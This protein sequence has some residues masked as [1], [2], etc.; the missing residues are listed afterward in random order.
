MKEN[1]SDKM[2]KKVS[3]AIK[4]GDQMMATEEK[5][6]LETAQRESA[7]RRQESGTEYKPKLFRKDENGLWVYKYANKAPFNPN[8]VRAVVE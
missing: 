5:I 2:W 8:E 4:K 7:K 3:E 1:E 6:V